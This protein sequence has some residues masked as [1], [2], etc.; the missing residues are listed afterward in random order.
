MKRKRYLVI[1]A[2]AGAL[3][4]SAFVWGSAHQAKQLTSA[5]RRP[6]PSL[7]DSTLTQA[8]SVTFPSLDGLSLSGWWL[9]S[10]DSKTT[11]ILLHGHGSNRRQMIA[12]AKLLHRHGYSVL[13][14]DARGHGESAGDLVS[15]GFHESND[16]LG[17]MDFARSKGSNKFGLIGASQ[18]G[19]TIALTGDR[20]KDVNWVVL[21]SVYSDLR[22]AVDRR[23]RYHAHLPGWLLGCLMIPFAE[24]KV[25]ASINQISPRAMVEKI[26]A[27]VFVL[28]GNR[29]RHTLTE[30]TQSLFGAVHSPKTLWLVEGAGHVDL[31]GFAKERYEERLLAF[32]ASARTPETPA[33]K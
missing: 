26:S 23:C 7:A 18:G 25:G 1:A 16:L 15:F 21:E 9:P 12:R 33:T 8:E 14:Y 6:V 32:I 24:S 11:V 30:D 3:G 22:T 2:T 13:L 17:A 31:Y 28:S 10:P 19:A 29:D 5:F 20:L 27:P 4:L